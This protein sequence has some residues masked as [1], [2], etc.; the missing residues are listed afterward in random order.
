[1]ESPELPKVST[2]SALDPF[3]R[4]R[5][6]AK[7]KA[8]A[9]LWISFLLLTPVTGCLYCTSYEEEWG[10]E[11]LQCGVIAAGL[12]APFT[13]YW[14]PRL[15][16]SLGIAAGAYGITY[17]RQ[18]PSNLDLNREDTTMSGRPLDSEATGKVLQALLEIV[19]EY[20]AEDGRIIVAAQPGKREQIYN[21]VVKQFDYTRD[22]R[23]RV[24][25]LAAPD[26]VR[27]LL[28]SG[29]AVVI[30]SSADQPDHFETWT[31]RW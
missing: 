30:L 19:R 11:S 6:E 15:L 7:R 23:F 28:R 18:R 5:A 13:S 22:S 1:M 20:K 27:S 10:P 8:I 21:D 14:L 16:I 12:V 2:R 4:A 29:K 26:K 9:A 25:D 17:R 24:D 3:R 31:R